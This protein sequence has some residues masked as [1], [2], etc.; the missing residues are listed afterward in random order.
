MPV[1]FARLTSTE[2]DALPREKTVFFFPVGPMED[3]GPHLPLGMDLAEADALCRLTAE[4]LEKD[5]PGWVGVLMP[6]APLGI[7]G[8]TTH[9]VLSVRAHV[10]RD[11]LVDACK[12]LM[13]AG[14]RHFVCFSGHLGPKQLT[15][16]EEAG[17]MLFRF[18]RWRGYFLKGSR[19]M[20][21]SA[22]SSLVTAREVFASPLVPDPL[23]HGGSRDTSVALARGLA[24]AEFASLPSVERE[25]SWSARFAKRFKKQLRGYW[26]DP[27]SASAARGE[28]ILCGTLDQVYPKLR[29][30]WEGANPNLLFRSWYSILPPNK[31]L[32]KVWILFL[33]A[34]VFLLAAIYMYALALLR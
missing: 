19:P 9:L 22:S 23:E 21:V 34:L 6:A 8:N 27:A 15:T 4:R 18:A 13:R 26:G 5:L 25:G 33:F 28:T 20:L 24:H 7:E 32:F 3:H 17:K 12:S 29:A 11:W 31:S 2:A 14:F 16:I 1:E 10:L 30:S